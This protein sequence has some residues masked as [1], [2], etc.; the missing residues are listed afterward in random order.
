MISLP[1]TAGQRPAHL[2]AS[3]DL[4]VPAGVSVPIGV[5]PTPP[6]IVF[7]LAQVRRH[8]VFRM[9]IQ[10]ALVATRDK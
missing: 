1:L 10:Q 7:G 8:F 3:K 4:V 6:E 9:V 2:F 5:K